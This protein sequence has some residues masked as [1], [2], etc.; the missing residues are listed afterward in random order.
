MNDVATASISLAVEGEVSLVGENCPGIVRLFCEG[1]D[2]EYLRW[3]YNATMLI[4]VPVIQSTFPSDADRSP[5]VDSDVVFKNPAFLTVEIVLVSVKSNKTI[6]GISVANF[7]TK[8]TVDLAQLAQQNITSITCG[9]FGHFTDSL[10][11]NVTIFRPSFIAP[12]TLKITKVIASY[13][14]GSLN[15]V[16][17][18]WTKMV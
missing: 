11:V 6:N 10:A 7:S 3:T 5:F 17:V 12:M 8:L 9:Q 15:S 4:D 13:Q 16:E 18:Q 2:L 1:V 14:S